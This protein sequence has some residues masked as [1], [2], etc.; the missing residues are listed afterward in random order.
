MLMHL[1]AYQ[2]RIPCAEASVEVLP[3][4]V[5]E[6]IDLAFIYAGEAKMDGV[7]TD[8]IIAML[9]SWPGA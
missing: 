2:E 6:V 3:G 8:E 7:L 5:V 9:E 4:Q 1:A